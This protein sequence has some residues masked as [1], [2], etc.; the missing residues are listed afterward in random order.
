M[1]KVVLL[2][3]D[4]DGTEHTFT[5]NNVVYMPGSPVNILSTRRLAEHFPDSN[6]NPDCKGTGV[7]SFYDEHVLYW[8]HKEHTKTFVTA[9]SGLPDMFFN[10][11]FSNYSAYVANI[12]KYYDDTPTWALASD[13][14]SA[15]ILPAGALDASV[16]SNLSFMEGMKLL[17]FDGSNKRVLVEFVAPVFVPDG[18]LK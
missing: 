15:K 18:Q 3:Q 11:S 5:I 4:D 1:G 10:T 16:T 12:T 2:V 14:D 13:S 8:N 6:G 17:Y 9:T 7:A